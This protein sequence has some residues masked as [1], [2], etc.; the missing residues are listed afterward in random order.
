MNSSS[1]LRIGIAAALGL[2]ALALLPA[3]PAAASTTLS[4]TTTTDTSPAS[5]PCANG[6]TTPPSPLS[7]RDAVC[8]AN[9]LGGVVTVSVPAG[10]YDLSHGELDV[11]T[12]AGQ[13][14]TLV[15]AG[16][17]STIID[18]QG[19]S[20]VLNFDPNIVGGV[21]GTVQG[22]TITG[23]SDSTFGGAGIIAGS[24]AASDTDQLTI[25][26][27]T[28]T[29]NN[30]NG[31]TPTETSNPGGG[32]QFIGG[33]LTITDSTISNNTSQS[34]AGAAVFYQ[35]EGQGSP[36]SFTMSGT[37]V[38][39]NNEVNSQ[40][41]VPTDGAVDLA[42]PGG[43][44]MSVTSST[45]E[46]NQADG[47]VGPVRGAALT[48][49]SGAVNVTDS[50]F[51]G[52]TVTDTSQA[53][54]SGG[55]AIATVTGTATFTDDRIA[56]NSVSPP[57]TGQAL[58][59]LGATVTATND[60]WGC[61][62]GPGSSGCDS[63]VGSATTAPRLTLTA[64][65][66]TVAANATAQV[67]ANLT[68][69]SAGS[70][71]GTAEDEFNGT[72]EADFTSP[73][74]GGASCSPGAVVFSGGTG[75]AGCTF[76]PNGQTGT[77]SVTISVDSQSITVPVTITQPPEIT[78]QPS[79]VTASPGD[80]ATFTA[81]ATGFPAPAVQWEVSANGG[82]SF[83]DIAGATGTT[84]SFTATAAENGNQY[85]A[86]FTNSTGTATTDAATLSESSAPGITSGASAAFTVGSSG[87]F[88]VTTTGVPT[89][90]VSESGTLPSGVSFTDNGDGTGTLSG[91]PETGTGGTYP[92]TFQASNGV[93]SPASQSFTLTVTEAPTFTSGNSAA[94]T[95][96][97]GGTFMVTTGGFPAPSLAESG[98]LPS[99]VSFT[100][101]GDGTATLAG[102]TIV[103]G[104]YPIT[105][106]AASSSGSA[107]QS[108]TLNVA[109]DSQ[110]ITFTS[111]PPAN[112]VVGQHY[113]VAATGGG[114]GNPVTFSIDSGS[115]GVCG[116]SGATV[117]FQSPGACQID[118]AQ[119]GNSQF[120]PATASQTVPVSMASTSTKLTVKPHSLVA[121]VKAV[122][123]GA[124]TPAGS[125]TFAVDGTTV[126]TA[127]LSGGTATLS[128]TVP[129]G[130]THSVAAVYGGDA[131]FAGSSA[132]TARS[133]PSITAAVTSPV[134]PTT[135]GWY[136]S[137]VTI[138]YTCTPSGAKLTG[139][140]PAATTLKDNGAGQ[141]VTRTIRASDGGV[142]SVTVSGINIDMV[143]PHV[144]VTGPVKGKTYF[145]AAPQAQ[146]VAS[147]M[148]SG[149]ASCTLSASVS[150]STVTDTG[151]ATDHAGNVATFSVSFT[152]RDFFVQG[153]PI[154]GGAFQ[155]K[156]GHTYTI[157]ALTKSTTQP[158]FYD[159]VPAG[160]TPHV[161]GSLLRKAGSQAG[162]HRF[163]LRV[164]VPDNLS[165][166]ALWDFGVKTGSV[167]N[168][169]EF[170]PLT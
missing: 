62:A 164:V 166:S 17:S 4:V 158:R 100:D 79:S 96:G 76:S 58:D 169:I 115:G 80:T 45:F 31:S 139:P 143:P 89:A 8:V 125:V 135:F 142:A 110:A 6:S 15:G 75:E 141:S 167:M 147:D 37:T 71:I 92:I 106:S 27:S 97:T 119:A 44:T 165:S 33:Q 149:L 2:G 117:T 7:L 41:V 68:D 126:G 102:T 74:P 108:F 161:A 134:P 91:T 61:N 78:S 3:V 51:S 29:A 52:N 56:G 26:D 93:G 104:S 77:G 18:A 84:L 88:T 127:T 138:T 86:V 153:A 136:R 60:W 124:G 9:N 155:L 95:A 47:N 123:P 137:A 118:A 132:S 50:D 39:G 5:G 114:S 46:G 81:A 113:T 145:G 21:A 111:T 152:V 42:A 48:L 146:C 34:S 85:R 130:Q 94:F 140:C 1:G 150:G 12:A 67:T 162:L 69:N 40:S 160:Q 112:A 43:V 87:S 101:N 99:G 55:A 129:A 154:S 151:T 156:E 103:A 25:D 63:V 72:T 53:S 54:G 163:T 116:I 90:S 159:A 13:N 83:S 109:P 16:A 11:G 98:P 107:Q 32:I 66:V 14:V 148:L 170:H 24:G 36:E 122:A 20:R 23:G 35:A 64:S 105:I 65:P 121:T 57:A 30:A 59:N 133:D 70:A 157:V 19:Q 38:A 28:I 82:A 10:T 144:K 131:S 49:E 128:D 22:V 73:E 168:L 120:A